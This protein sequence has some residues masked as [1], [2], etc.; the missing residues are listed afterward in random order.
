MRTD[1]AQIDVK[2]TPTPG[3]SIYN[4]IKEILVLVQQFGRP[5]SF[6]FNDTPGRVFPGMTEE[7]A[8]ALWYGTRN[9]K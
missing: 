5:I 2:V 8:Y 9:Q 4:M 6:V 7:E 3:A 1:I